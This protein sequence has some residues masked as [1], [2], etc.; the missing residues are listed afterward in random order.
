M[1]KSARIPRLRAHHPVKRSFES[2]QQSAGTQNEE[3]SESIKSGDV[4]HVPDDSPP[5]SC[6]FDIQTLFVPP[7]IKAAAN[8]EK[9]RGSGGIDDRFARITGKQ[10][11]VQLVNCKHE[12]VGSGWPA[13]NTQNRAA[14]RIDEKRAPVT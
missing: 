3:Q 10:R 12:I 5:R 6:P 8:E 11:D 7:K 14:V 13:T 4:V 2:N 9:R 1:R